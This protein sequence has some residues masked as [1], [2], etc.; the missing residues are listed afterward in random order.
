MKFKSLALTTGIAFSGILAS[1]AVTPA[2]AF[3]TYFGEDQSADSGAG[4]LTNSIAAEQLFLSNLSGAGTETFESFADGD[5][6]SNIIFPGV[7]TATISSTTGSVVEGLILD[8]NNTPVGRFPVLGSSKYYEV[9]DGT[10]TIDFAAPVAA[11]G[12]YGTDI[13]DFDGQLTLQLNDTA[14]TLLTVPNTLNGLNGSALYYG[15]IA[16]PGQTFTSLTFGNT[17]TGVDFFGFDNLTVGTLAQVTTSTSVPEPFTI[18][19]TL[20]GGSAAIRMRKKLKSG[21]KG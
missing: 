16:A 6:A 9:D 20:V 21:T 7:G 19:G 11:F 1:G 2:S 4:A 18:I 10:F 14:N 15:F 13:G 8:Q 12:F 5:P 17:N 3:T